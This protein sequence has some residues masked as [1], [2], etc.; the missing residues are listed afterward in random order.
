MFVKKDDTIGNYIPLREEIKIMYRVKEKFAPL[1]IGCLGTVSR[2]FDKYIK[3]LG[4]EYVQTS[5]TL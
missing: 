3:E 4:I 2:S 5:A 1:V